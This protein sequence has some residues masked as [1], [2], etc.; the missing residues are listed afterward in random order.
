MKTGETPVDAR[1]F[2]L[3]HILKIRVMDPYGARGDAKSKM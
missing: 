2:I 3:Y 1:S